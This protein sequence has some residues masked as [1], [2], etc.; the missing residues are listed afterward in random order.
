MESVAKIKELR[1]KR[2]EHTKLVRELKKER[3][4]FNSESKK[5]IAAVK[6]LR[7]QKDK[8]KDKLGR[9]NSAERL[10]EEVEKLEYRLETAALPFEKE[11]ELN[12]VIKE[13]K[14]D[15]RL[16]SDFSDVVKKLKDSSKKL[17]GM[18]RRSD[19]VHSKIE[20][21]ASSSQK[22]HEEILKHSKKAD[23][24]KAKLVAASKSLD[25]LKDEQSR[26]EKQ[27]EEKTKALKAAGDK[28]KGIDADESRKKSEEQEKR[29]K[30]AEKELAEKMKSGKK[31]TMDDLLKL[32]SD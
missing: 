15:L 7:S 11:R 22:F 28:L 32:K 19:G 1:A 31:L 12:K 24:F 10:A 16:S 9:R 14:A 2:D 8:A 21:H 25:E 5:L 27:F 26:L 6:R 3:E 23:D 20:K 29:V 13:K 18:R 17:D 4:S 30:K